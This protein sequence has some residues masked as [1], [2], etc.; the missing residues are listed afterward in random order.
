MEDNGLTGHK[1]EI[2]QK[3]YAHYE[4]ALFHYVFY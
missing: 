2:A 3:N 1:C 4:P